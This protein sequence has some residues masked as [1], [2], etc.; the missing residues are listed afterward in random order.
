MYDDQFSP[1]KK[2]LTEYFYGKFLGLTTDRND[3]ILSKNF[4]LDK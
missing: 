1:Q 4:Y 2:D 3:R